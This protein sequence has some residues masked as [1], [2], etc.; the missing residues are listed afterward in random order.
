MRAYDIDEAVESCYPDFPGYEEA[1]FEARISW[2]VPGHLYEI[3]HSHYKDEHGGPLVEYKKAAALRPRSPAA[4]TSAPAQRWRPGE[5]VEA[6]YMHA[7][8][9]GHVYR[10]LPNGTYDVYFKH[11]RLPHDVL[12]NYAPNEL[13]PWLVYN[14]RADRWANAPPR[15]ISEMQSEYRRK[16][17]EVGG[18]AVP[19]VESKLTTNR[20]RSPSLAKDVETAFLQN[21]SNPSLSHVSPR[22]RSSSP[23]SSM[24]WSTKKSRYSPSPGVEAP[25]SRKVKTP[26]VGRRAFGTEHEPHSPIVAIAESP[27]AFHGRSK[28]SPKRSLQL[29]PG[30]RISSPSP[31]P[32]PASRDSFPHDPTYR[33][34]DTRKRSRSPSPRS[35]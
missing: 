5:A 30:Y 16:M 8:W 10:R 17:K 21:T 34:G 28:R 24:S 33:P 18:S 32:D 15:D 4:S 9:G 14:P 1:W 29:S 26:A 6:L 22:S 2:I 23:S 19:P 35:P 12:A 7:W 25:S 20:K 13:R 3:K 11:F 27:R 31:S